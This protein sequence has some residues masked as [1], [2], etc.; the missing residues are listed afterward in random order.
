MALRFDNKIFYHI[1]KTGGS[2]VRKIIESLTDD[3]SQIGKTHATPYDTSLALYSFC[4]VRDPI[5]WYRSYFRY[6]I[7]GGRGG[8]N[9]DCMF[10]KVCAADTF[11]KFCLNVINTTIAGTTGYVGCLY[12]P[13]LKVNR[14]LRFER[15]DEELADFF[16][17][18]KNFKPIAPVKVSPKTINTRLS[19]KT[20]KKLRRYE[21]GICNFLGY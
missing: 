16:K 7:S 18:Y 19:K 12:I 14:I 6:R 8:W 17:H 2:Y 13:F 5:D 11:E 21:A 9:M 4:V 3:W 20:L 10:D 15:L 1:P